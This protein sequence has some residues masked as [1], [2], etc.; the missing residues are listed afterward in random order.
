M[1]QIIL[2]Q[3]EQLK[4]KYPNSFIKERDDGSHVLI[5]ENFPLPKGWNKNTTTVVVFIPGC[6]PIC[7]PSCFWADKDLRLEG[8]GVPISTCTLKNIA[9]VSDTYDKQWFG[10]H[11][12]RWYPNR[13]TLLTYANFVKTRFMVAR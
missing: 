6:Y 2:E 10:Y 8:G 12:Q 11:P 3:L 9:F 7:K 1:N 13:D 5:I 4:Q